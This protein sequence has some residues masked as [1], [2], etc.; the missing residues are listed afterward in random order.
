MLLIAFKCLD[1]CIAKKK[2]T[3][4]SNVTDYL[5]F[6][7]NVFKQALLG[8]HLV[9]FHF[10]PSSHKMVQRQLHIIQL[11]LVRLLKITKE[12]VLSVVRLS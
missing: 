10:L 6:F 5:F 11:R 3:Q 4:L 9:S 7:T 1:Y 2:K 12:K 8:C